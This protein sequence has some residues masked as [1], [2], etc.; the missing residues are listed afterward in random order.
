MIARTDKLFEVRH[1]L[2]RAD[3]HIRDL[4]RS[5]ESYSSRKPYS[6]AL[7]YTT[8]QADVID[9]IFEV[10]DVRLPP[11]S[12]S[13]ILGD[14]VQNMRIALD[15]LACLIAGN[16]EVSFPMSNSSYPFDRALK[17]AKMNLL[18][19]DV[20]KAIRDVQPD[21]RGYENLANLSKLSNVDKHHF[22]IV[23]AVGMSMLSND[24]V[25]S[26]PITPSQNV[27]IKLDS[28]V[29]IGPFDTVTFGAPI[30]LKKGTELP[31]LSA[32]KGLKLIGDPYLSVSVTFGEPTRIKGKVVHTEAFYMLFTINRIVDKLEK[33]IP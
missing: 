7:K 18:P 4:E 19:K 13:L 8:E 32:A 10:T 27:E 31:P 26:W 24:V 20:I 15:Y 2:E 25:F 11:P 33:F 3:K 6:L 16:T 5:V 17:D 12:V 21:K 22:L 9:Y 1:K 30:P 23:T 28:P 14:A 29:F